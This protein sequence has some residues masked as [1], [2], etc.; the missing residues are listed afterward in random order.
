MI[1]NSDVYYY[2]TRWLKYY[3]QCIL[4]DLLLIED[5]SS[6]VNNIRYGKNFAKEFEKHI[7]TF[8]FYRGQA[9][10]EVPLLLFNIE[11][12]G[13]KGKCTHTFIVTVQYRFSSILPPFNAVG[14]IVR[15]DYD[16]S[17]YGVEREFDEMFDKVYEMFEGLVFNASGMFE[18]R[19]IWHDINKKLPNRAMIN[20]NLLGVDEHKYETE[21]EI[22]ARAWTFKFNL[23]DRNCGQRININC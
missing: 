5:E 11:E 3:G 14:D 13:N 1:R 20:G 6:T 4:D 8:E 18:T 23:E 15:K 16:N 19:N 7:S 10:A 12:I 2:I 21:N 17:S 22:Y 9:G